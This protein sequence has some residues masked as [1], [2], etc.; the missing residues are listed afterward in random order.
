M[1]TEVVPNVSAEDFRHPRKAP[2]FSEFIRQFTEACVNQTPGQL[3]LF[4]YFTDQ[5]PREQVCHP[6]MEAQILQVSGIA[7]YDVASR[8]HADK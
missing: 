8:A 1:L 5:S 2:A 7:F 4:V 3:H 6:D